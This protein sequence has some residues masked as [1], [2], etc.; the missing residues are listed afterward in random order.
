MQRF[1]TI[2]AVVTEK[3]AHSAAYLSKNQDTEKSK[4]TV[5]EDEY[6]VTQ[7][8]Q[9]LKSVLHPSLNT[10][11]TLLS[12]DRMEIMGEN[13]FLVVQRCEYRSFIRLLN[14]VWG[15][16]P[17]SLPDKNAENLHQ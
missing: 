16:F 9:N 1:V 15:H 4:K 13:E 8:T 14:N 7:N 2:Y 12:V 3:N 6:S 10:P 5:F 11:G 17:P